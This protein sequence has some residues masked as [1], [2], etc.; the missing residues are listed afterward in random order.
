MQT[1]TIKL[2]DSTIE[3]LDDRAQ[4]EYDGN[5]SEAV[6]EL[7]DKGL[8]MTTSKP[9]GTDYNASSPPSMLARTM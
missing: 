4:E 9:S 5:R 7:L 3:L 2:P 8:Q 6:R 1:I